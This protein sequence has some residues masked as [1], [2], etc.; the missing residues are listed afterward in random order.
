MR[1]Y[2]CMRLYAPEQDVAAAVLRTLQ[3][4]ARG[5]AGE[6]HTVAPGRGARL[7]AGVVHERAWVVLIRRREQE[8]CLPE[9]LEHVR[10]QRHL[11]QELQGA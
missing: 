9:M 8:R 1:G 3:P 7:A 6:Q 11:L 2:G 10:P 4:Q 5:R